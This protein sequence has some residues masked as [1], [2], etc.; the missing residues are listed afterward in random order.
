MGLGYDLGMMLWSG[1]R[2]EFWIRIGT[3]LTPF[4][5]SFILHGKRLV[6]KKPVLHHLLNLTEIFKIIH[7]DVLG[8]RQWLYR[9]GIKYMC[10]RLWQNVTT[11]M[12]HVILSSLWGRNPKNSGPNSPLL[13][14]PSRV[15]L[16]S[17]VAFVAKW[18]HVTWCFQSVLL[19]HLYFFIFLSLSRNCRVG[20][21]E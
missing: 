20:S 13:T 16:W 7:C 10:Q 6:G 14:T 21:R 17:A 8:N 3:G 19:T 12:I 1:S 4:S 11:E 15:Q 5:L 9:V 2:L 18:Y